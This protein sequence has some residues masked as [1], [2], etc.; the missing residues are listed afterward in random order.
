MGN[1]SGTNKYTGDPGWANTTTYALT[2]GGPAYTKGSARSGTP[3][4]DI[5]NAN[6][7]N[8]PALGARL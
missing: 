8:P 1:V 6:R 7:P 3:S 4:V 5:D 2:V